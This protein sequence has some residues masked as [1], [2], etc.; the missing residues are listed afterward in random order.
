M[1][2]TASRLRGPAS[3]QHPVTRGRGH[4]CEAPVSRGH[5]GSPPG[6]TPALL[7][8]PVWRAWNEAP[9]LTSQ[10]LAPRAHQPERSAPI[11]APR[12]RAQALNLLWARD[13]HLGNLF[14][15]EKPSLLPGL[16]KR[17]KMES[18]S[19]PPLN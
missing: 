19:G 13:P 14:L 1:R 17:M 12:L 16:R 9:E 10:G 6:G 2:P 5:R 8:H 4:V 3:S 15:G 11:P 7:Q 18:S